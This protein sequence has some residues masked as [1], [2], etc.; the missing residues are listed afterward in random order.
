MNVCVTYV[1]TPID[2]R[3]CVRVRARAC[4]EYKERRDRVQLNLKMYPLSRFGS[5]AASPLTPM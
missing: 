1:C 4:L 5:L 2:V 3:V